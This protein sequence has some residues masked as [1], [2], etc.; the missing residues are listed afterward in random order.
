MT[1]SNLSQ[2]SQMH[3][4]KPAPAALHTEAQK[5]EDEPL[6]NLSTRVDLLSNEVATEAPVKAPESKHTSLKVTFTGP[7]LR[8]F[9][10]LS[11]SLEVSDNTLIAH[12]ISGQPIDLAKCRREKRITITAIEK[13][14]LNSRSNFSQLE[15]F[16]KDSSNKILEQ[17][18]S[19]IEFALK[20]IS[21]AFYTIIERSNKTVEVLDLAVANKDYA[22]ALEIYKTENINA[23]L[24][25]HE[26]K[27]NRALNQHRKKLNKKIDESRSVEINT[28]SKNYRVDRAAAERFKESKNT[29]F[30]KRSLVSQGL[31]SCFE[32]LQLMSVVYQEATTFHR[33]LLIALNELNNH[34]I[35]RTISMAVDT[36]NESLI[37]KEFKEITLKLQAVYNILIENIPKL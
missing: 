29:A 27:K 5:V 28:N 24:K 23:V 26:V 8:A 2:S 32:N 16:I 10:A 37:E 9:K 35:S 3:G 30:G 33:K 36:D 31:V 22:Q 13:I 6:F 4:L 11:E 34:F 1:D 15:A 14:M 21:E 12:A 25:F 17:R 18:R 19:R 20:K 7:E